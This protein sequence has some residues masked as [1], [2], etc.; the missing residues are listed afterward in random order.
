M[1]DPSLVGTRR[2]QL[3]RSRTVASCCSA[4]LLA[5]SGG[6]SEDDSLSVDRNSDETGVDTT[7][8]HGTGAQ[9]PR[10][11]DASSPAA[12][13]S[14]DPDASN[15]NPSAAP[16]PTA[17]PH[18][19]IAE[20]PVTLMRRLSNREYNNTV[21]DLLGTDLTPARDFLKETAHGFD[22]IAS[23]LGMTSAQYNAYFTAAAALAED[24][25]ADSDLRAPFATCDGAEA[26]CISAWVRDFLERAF[27]RKPNAEEVDTYVAVYEKAKTLELSHLDSMQQVVRAVLAS[28]GFLYRMEFDDSAP[29]VPRALTGYEL[30]SRLSY[31]LWSTMPDAALFAAAAAGEL[32]TPT[33][34]GTQVQRMIADPRSRSLVDS[35]AW[36]WLGMESLE[37]HAVLR[38]VFPD[39]DE[40]L[41]E[42]MLGEARAYLTEFVLG[43]QDWRTFLTADLHFLNRRLASHYG[44]G[45]DG[46][47]DALVSHAGDTSSRLGFIGTAGF[48]TVS[49]FAH[50]TSP[51]LRAKWVLEELLCSPPPPPPAGLMV[52]DLD[53]QDRSNEAASIDNVRERLELHRSDAACAS[54]HSYLDPLGLALENFDAV[55]RYRTTYAD[56]SPVD[57]EGQLPD[58]KV[59]TGLPDLA[60]LMADDA[61][62]MACTVEKMFTYAMGR[63]PTAS[64]APAL[65]E[66]EERWRDGATQL[67]ALVKH[68]T[69]SAAFTQ[70]QPAVN[71]ESN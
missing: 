2:A 24:V 50:R 11:T 18:A 67:P 57:A 28:P 13:E 12:S 68:V 34:V 15:D 36:Q 65:E 6:V 38:D 55:G 48:L 23:T 42:A 44:I 66:L 29:P 3:A 40:E 19:P 9:G 64:E 35:F 10:P 46:L 25:F 61:R 32:A 22:N 52:P 14:A 27:R 1:N 54:C 21:H 60:Q 17:A 4:L 43:E 51:T 47:D 62:F 5:C 26:T 58:G 39:W 41:R 59:L 70:R 71:E 56:G 37:S 16:A 30:A 8:E 33:Q 20:A 7:D 69:A 45:T 63:A 49:S 53:A 31:F